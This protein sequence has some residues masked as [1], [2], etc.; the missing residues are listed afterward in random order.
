M[1]GIY[2]HIPFCRQA[3]RYCDFYFTVSNQYQDRFSASLLKELQ[4]SA[5]EN[6]GLMMHSLYLGGGTPSTLSEENLKSIIDGIKES[7]RFAGD[8]EFT[9]ECNPDDLDKTKLAL[10]KELGFNRISLGIQSFREED[11]ILMR[12]S[13]NALQAERAVWDAAEAGFENITI[14]LIYGIPG[15]STEGW[16]DNIKKALS[17]PLKHISAY[18]L[19]FEEGT[20][21]EHWRKK[22]R[23]SPLAEEESVEMFRLMR[24]ELTEA[25]MDH[26][27]ISNFSKEG[28]WS[29]HNRLYW[30]GK[31]YLGFG[32]SAHSFNGTTRYWNEPSLKKYMSALE[33]GE[34][35]REEEVLSNK[36][37][38]H[39]YLITSLR[40]R[41]GVDLTL[42][43]DRFGEETEKHFRD[44]AGCFLKEG[45]MWEQGARLAIK[46]ENWLLADHII[47]ELFLK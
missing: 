31:P 1:S 30:S 46:P 23:I 28:W 3:C 6:E 5:P 27:E 15:Q 13:H 19:S 16:K 25:G 41:E 21:F 14:D 44:K 37:H 39:D 8:A 26:Y 18:H 36:E 9:I 35:L 17:L 43:T 32:P 38:Y 7:Y 34:L 20:V 4:I 45:L 11:L 40:T 2:I 42:L 24:K 29:R 22:G 12:R 10:F 47:R 33:K